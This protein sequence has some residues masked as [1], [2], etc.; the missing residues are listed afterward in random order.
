MTSSSNDY[1][2][3]T[4]TVRSIGELE[5]VGGFPT[6]D[7][8]RRA[9]DQL[10]LQRA[11]QVYL[12]FIPFM[13]QQAL[14]DSHEGPDER[15]P[16]RCRACSITRS[17]GRS[18]GS[19]LTFNTESIYCSA[20]A[21]AEHSPVVL[22]TPPNVLGVIDDGWMRYVTDIGNVGPDR[23]QGGS[24]LLVHDG[25]EGEV[26]DRV[27]FFRTPDLQELGDGARL[28]RRHGRGRQRAGLVSRELPD[29]PAGGPAPIPEATYVPFSQQHLRTTHVRDAAYFDR[30]AE[31][32]QCD[33]TA[34][35]ER[36]LEIFGV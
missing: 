29:L 8:I 5:Y 31:A 35:P 3:T 27:P 7:T 13:S 18:T 11:T 34:T 33:P 4:R 28:R 36:V 9:Y 30:L 15:G 14:F 16:A 12:E 17:A 26:P 19:G 22:E 23:G 20:T 21:E 25:Y 1:D 32:V 24:F 6:D 10:D 2:N